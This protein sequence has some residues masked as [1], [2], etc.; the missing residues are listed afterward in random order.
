[1]RN[2][3][4][5]TQ[6]VGRA[7]EGL[8]VSV[9]KRR[10]RGGQYN[11]N[12]KQTTQHNNFL[13][14]RK[15]IHTHTHTHTHTKR[16]G[17]ERRGTGLNS[18]N[19]SALD[20]TTELRRCNNLAGSY[21]FIQIQ[22]NFF[23]LIN[24]NF[25]LFTEFYKQ[26]WAPTHISLTILL[27]S[28]F[29]FNLN[30]HFCFRVNNGLDWGIRGQIKGKAARCLP[31]CRWCCCLCWRDRR[32]QCWRS[33]SWIMT[34]SPAEWRTGFCAFS[35]AILPEESATESDRWRTSS[36]KPD[37]SSLSSAWNR[38]QKKWNMRINLKF[39]FVSVFVFQFQYRY[40]RR[41]AT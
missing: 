40:P 25:L 6:R 5:H 35:I 21:N 4:T 19:F 33:D 39:K 29:F 34:R 24:I 12:R 16:G 10:H 3:H 20:F 41:S 7:M 13:Q 32:R 8:R 38:K 15:G 28:F 36:V 9:W 26:N 23:F 22:I 11:N 30:H 14:E 37:T 18:K 2:T 1:M 31:Y 27:W 17:R